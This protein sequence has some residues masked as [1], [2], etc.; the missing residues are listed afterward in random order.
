MAFFDQQTIG[1]IAFL[2]S[3][4]GS[5]LYFASI[6]KGDTKPHLFTWLVFSILTSI[7]FFAQLSDN[8]GPAAWTMG[9]TALSCLAT[10]LLAL[11]HGEKS[12]SRGDYIALFFSLSAIV[13]WLL[14]KDPLISVILICLIDSVGMYPTLRKAWNV[15]YS[16][17]LFSYSLA[18]LKF[19]VALFAIENFSLVTVLYP[20][21]IVIVNSILIIECLLRR[22]IVQKPTN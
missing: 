14:T 16:E 10:A 9:A 19:F 4:A 13:P 21:T 1:L 22:G 20:V 2:I 5:V 12:R 8:A 11:K 17:N 18:N 15:P 6:F 3:V 7:G